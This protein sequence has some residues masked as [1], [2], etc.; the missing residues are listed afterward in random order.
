MTGLTVEKPE[1]DGT[2][3]E[4][5]ASVLAFFAGTFLFLIGLFRIGF[6]DNIL[7]RPLLAG[8]VNA[9]GVTIL[10]E[11]I[12]PLFGLE[13]KGHGWRKIIYWFKDI[14]NMNWLTFGIGFVTIWLILVIKYGKKKF[15]WIK[16]IPETL[17]VVII[18]T[19]VSKYGGFEG[20]TKILG[21]IPQG[22][23]APT[24]PK[25]KIDNLGGVVVDGIL[26]GLIGFVEHIA[27]GKIYA[28]K[29]NYH[30]SPNRELV[31]VGVSNLIGSFFNAYPAFGSL[32]RSS[33]ADAM[34]ATSQLFSVVIFLMVMLTLLVGGPLFYYLPRAVMTGI[35]ITAAIGLFEAHDLLFMLKIRAWKELIQSIVTL[36][37]TIFLGIELGLVISLGISVLFIIKHTTYPQIT[38]LGR[39]KDTIQYRDIT[40]YDTETFPGILIAKI[41]D[42]L[43]FANIGQIKSLFGRIERLGDPKA[44]PAE[45]GSGITPLKALIIHSAN[46]PSMD[47][48]SVQILGEMVQDY[49][50]RDVCVCWVKLKDELKVS[51][52]R[53]GIISSM[54]DENLFSTTHEAVVYAQN[55]LLEQ[56][57]EELKF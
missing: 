50:K 3:P 1:N 34:G 4:Y 55:L 45:T 38:L 14:K 49:R 8:F 48:S 20:R 2:P 46:I 28:S 23:K 56:N 39:V 7:S 16:F 19:I 18:G 27:I 22:I 21:H 35:I 32:A 17:V 24:V 15:Q 10:L 36:L 47:S 30:V 12:Q 6:L 31:S 42:P 57:L 33:I 40:Q 13:E 41:E 52:K 44:H 37:L 51:F 5:I 25:F 43:Y 9:I 11:Q 26:L 54:D 53:A 29:Y